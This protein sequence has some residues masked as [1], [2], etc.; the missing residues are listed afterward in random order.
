MTR[1]NIRRN[2]FTGIGLIYANVFYFILHSKIDHT[3]VKER[4]IAGN[5]MIEI[6]TLVFVIHEIIYVYKVYGIQCDSFVIYI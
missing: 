1:W 5:T 2:A 3:Y 6:T 4:I